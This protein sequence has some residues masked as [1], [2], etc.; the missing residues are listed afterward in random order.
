MKIS[1]CHQL[2][3]TCPT[4]EVVAA[5]EQAVDVS[6]LADNFLSFPGRAEDPVNY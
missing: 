5:N 3:P 4:T 6:D 2:A 1:C